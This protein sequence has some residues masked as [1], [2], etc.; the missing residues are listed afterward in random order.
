MKLKVLKLKSENRARNDTWHSD[1]VVK[2]NRCYDEKE[3]KGG[4]RLKK[5]V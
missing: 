5:A 3:E 2:G 1:S 4:E